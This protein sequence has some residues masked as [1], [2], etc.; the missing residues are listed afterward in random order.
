LDFFMKKKEN[1]NAL[2]RRTRFIKAHLRPVVV[3]G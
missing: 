2:P 1:E 3:V